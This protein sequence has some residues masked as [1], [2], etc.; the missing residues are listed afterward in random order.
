M[1]NINEPKMVMLEAA[2][3]PNGEVMHYGQSLGFINAEQKRL[4]KSGAH[5]QS[6]GRECVIALSPSVA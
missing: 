1:R 5:K 4:I 6:R 2:L 3:M